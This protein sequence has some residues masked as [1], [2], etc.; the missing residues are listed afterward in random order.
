MKPGP[1]SCQYLLL[2]GLGLLLCVKLVAKTFPVDHQLRVIGIDLNL[3]PK[4]VYQVL[5]PVAHFIII[6]F[7]DR[8]CDLFV[9]HQAWGFASQDF[10]QGKFPCRQVHFLAS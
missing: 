1:V 3:V 10:Q 5:N 9:S 2:D 7:P 4:Q 6:I 8:I